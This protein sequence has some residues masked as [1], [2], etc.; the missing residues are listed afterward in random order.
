MLSHNVGIHQ[1]I[2]QV[3][4]V[5]KQKDQSPIYHAN[6]VLKGAE[7]NYP[8]FEKLTLAVLICNEAASLF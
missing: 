6:Q 8:T 5:I 1:A 2:I 4:V 3:L 7:L